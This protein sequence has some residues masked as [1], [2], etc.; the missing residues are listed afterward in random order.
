[1]TT[2]VEITLPAATLKGL[3]CIAGKTERRFYLNGV[4]FDPAGYAVA[5]DGAAMLAVRLTAPFDGA[6]FVVPR[7][8]IE[9]ALKG[10]GAKLVA[11]SNVEVT[12]GRLTFIGGTADFTPVDAQYPAW[13]RVIPSSPSGEVAH[14]DP[15]R[16]MRMGDGIRCIEGSK[17]FI[18]VVMPNG[19][20]SGVVLGALP[21]VLGVIMPLST[22]EADTD[23]AHDR[24]AA[25][26]RPETAKA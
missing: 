23:D 14:F 19:K 20:A 6:G 26:L 2:E 16:V 11:T 5:T 4:Y 12:R 18:P 17:R 24:I 25:F 9:T 13:Q 1:M 21:A 3:L 10:L 15:A 8:A 22:G 7:A